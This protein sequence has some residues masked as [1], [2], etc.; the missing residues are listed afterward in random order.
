MSTFSM[1]QQEADDFTQLI[2]DIGGNLGLYLGG[3]LLTLLELA[4]IIMMY[5]IEKQKVSKKKV[6]PIT[7]TSA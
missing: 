6:A 4:D 2:C 7:V 5:F 3:S 1:T